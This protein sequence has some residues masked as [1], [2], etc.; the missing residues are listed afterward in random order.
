MYEVEVR[1]I[2]QDGKQVVY[3]QRLHRIDMG[4]FANQLNTAYWVDVEPEPVELAQTV[5]DEAVSLNKAY[6]GNLTAVESLG[7]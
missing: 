4:K 2:E 7:G 3:F 6:V 1:K 5:F